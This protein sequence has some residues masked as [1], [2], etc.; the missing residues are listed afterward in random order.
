MMSDM[1]N[2]LTRNGRIVA[3]RDGMA[4][5]RVE[6]PAGCTSCGSRGSCGSG[7]AAE[8]TVV[9]PVA[10]TARPGDVVTLSLAE[11]ALVRSALLVYFLPAA[12]TLLGAI[13]LAA[14]GDLAAIAGAACGLG[15]GLILMRL[16]G[17]RSPCLPAVLPAPTFASQPFGD[18]P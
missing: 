8:T 3:I 4:S 7:K 9:L 14:F 13:A 1:T 2:A 15:L 18:L 6:L 16:L 5:I 11:S 17:R 12:S 10:A